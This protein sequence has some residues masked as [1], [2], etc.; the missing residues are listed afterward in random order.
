MTYRFRPAMSSW[1]EGQSFDR[2]VAVE[3]PTLPVPPRISTREF[4]ADLSPFSPHFVGE[5]AMEIW[6][7]ARAIMACCEVRSYPSRLME[8]LGEGAN[9][10]AVSG[11]RPLSTQRA[12]RD[13]ES[14]RTIKLWLDRS[15]RNQMVNR[16]DLLSRIRHIL[17][18]FLLLSFYF[19]KFF[20]YY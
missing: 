16:F 14:H 3:P 11:V 8:G 7:A 13:D 9:V 18:A 20:I 2:A 1:R 15:I 12:V 6:R 4:S 17:N 10:A 19:S 5:M